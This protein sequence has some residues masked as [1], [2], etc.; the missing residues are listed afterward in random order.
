MMHIAFC[1]DTNYIMPAGVAMVSVCENNKNIDINFH[2]VITDEGT[3]PDEVDNKVKPLLDIANSYNKQVNV[4]RI[5]Q[6][7]I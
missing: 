4:Y 3:S 2:L 5:S 1:T 7:R 6:K